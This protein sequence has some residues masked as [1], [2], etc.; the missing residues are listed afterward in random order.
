[1]SSVDRCPRIRLNHVIET[2]EPASSVCSRR[3]VGRGLFASR[4]WACHRSGRGNAPVSDV[5][6][7]PEPCKGVTMGRL[8]DSSSVNRHKGPSFW[9]CCLCCPWRANSGGLFCHLVPRAMPLGCLLGPFRGSNTR[10]LV[11]RRFSFPPA[12]GASAS[13]P[14]RHTRYGPL[15]KV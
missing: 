9:F 12:N 8:I 15:P 11:T 1:A 14:V 4:P 7:S 6:T 13:A 2:F 5:E 3:L 10:V